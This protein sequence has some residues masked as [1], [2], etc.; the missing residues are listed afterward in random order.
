LQAEIAAN[1]FALRGYDAQNAIYSQSIAYYKQSLDLVT[2]QFVGEIASAL[3]VARVESLLFST[4]TRLAQVQGQRQV[5]EQAIAILVNVAPARLEPVIRS[6]TPASTVSWPG[7]KSS[8]SIGASVAASVGPPEPPSLHAAS[9]ASSARP[10][11]R[12]R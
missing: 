8:A 6:K 11:D 7:Q 2:A 9:A 10:R 12:I 4:E 1:Y 5:T 3:D